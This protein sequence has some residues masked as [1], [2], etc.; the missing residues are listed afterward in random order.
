[1]KCWRYRGILGI[2]GHSV[3]WGRHSS[4]TE[5]NRWLQWK[6]QRIKRIDNAIGMW[7]KGTWKVRF[8]GSGGGRPYWGTDL[9][10]KIQRI[11]GI[12]SM[13]LGM[14]MKVGVEQKWEQH[15]QKTVVKKRRSAILKDLERRPTGLEQNAERVVPD[16]VGELDRNQ[17]I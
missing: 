2:T 9:W 15:L 4:T 13:T 8:R 1:M 12:S 7:S 14:G 11:P 16:E 5:I 10:T 17:K 3:V 6:V